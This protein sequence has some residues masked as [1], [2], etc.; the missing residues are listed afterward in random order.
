MKMPRGVEIVG[1]WVD[2]RI[3]RCVRGLLLI[4]VI[5]SFA[6]LIWFNSLAVLGFTIEMYLPFLFNSARMGDK[7][8]NAKR[9]K[10]ARGVIRNG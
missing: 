9:A 1:R 2:S 3:E 5:S 7:K 10:A 4:A 6:N 8:A